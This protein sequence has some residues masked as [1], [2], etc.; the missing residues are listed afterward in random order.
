M[1]FLVFLHLNTVN[2]QFIWLRSTEKSG[3]TVLFACLNCFIFFFLL[4][5]ISLGRSGEIP[6][7]FPFSFLALDITS[8]R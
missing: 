6:K 7:F 4:S 8:S 3:L 1:I 2:K 5:K